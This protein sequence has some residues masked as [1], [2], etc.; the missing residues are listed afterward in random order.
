MY[1][2]NI[3]LENVRQFTH[4]EFNF[5]SGF[6][7]LIGENGTGKT[8]VLHGLLASLGS[9]RQTG[10]R[11]G[12]SDQDIRVGSRM[13]RV[14]TRV[15]EEPSCERIL[16]YNKKFGK[17][18]S[19]RGNGSDLTV[20][21][22]GSKE[23]STNALK[24]RRAPDLRNQSSREFVSE[25][26]FLYQN[27]HGLVGDSRPEDRFGR[28]EE[29]SSFVRDVLARV[30]PQ[31]KNF[32]W[33]FEPYQCS[34]I[35]LSKNRSKEIPGGKELEKAIIRYLLENPQNLSGIEQRSIKI[36]PK[37]H[38]LGD[39]K[40][41]SVTPPF[42][43][44]LERFKV[45]GDMGMLSELTAEVRLTPRIVIETLAGKL[46]LS[47]LSDGQQRLF[48]L[49]VDIARNL[50]LYAQDRIENTPA[51]VLID[52]IDVHLHPR[53]QRIMVPA[54]EDLFPCCQ[55]IATTHS[56]FVIQ[57]IDLRK[58][59]RI[60]SNGLLNFE[61]ESISIEDIV[62]D[63]QGI[64]MP[65]RGRRYEKMS[66]AAERYFHL[67]KQEDVDDNDLESAEQEYRLASEPFTTNPAINALLQVQKLDWRARKK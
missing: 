45:T 62:E 9:P 3:S 31:F 40:S 50:S 42:Y 15:Q 23:S 24:S 22:Y 16:S 33:R 53:W 63:I 12:L 25:E 47:Q 6:N 5:R 21:Y 64:D 55:F 38:I 14:K 66:H 4:A 2:T 60:G 30:S 17:R 49:L 7:L 39:S 61:N 28:S 37:G 8:T 48:S 43:E 34:L 36:H 56:P 52:E 19:R 44:I 35:A 18:S 59:I 13:L 20:L 54:L 32:H 57:A 1:V 11:R 58:V 26:M 51:V 67:L 27:E 29:V 41:R 46:L 10:K 65:Q